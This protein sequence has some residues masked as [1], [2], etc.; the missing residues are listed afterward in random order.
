M[1]QPKLY[2]ETYG[3]QMNVNDSEVV[4]SILGKNGFEMTET[5]EDASLIILNTC[6]VRD[7][8]ENKIF[9]RL[10]VIK[11]LKKTNNELLVGVIGC[12]AERLKEQLFERD[13]K[14]DVVC[15]PDS[16]RNIPELVNIARKNN[17]AINVHLSDSETYS[18]INPMRLGHNR[19]SA[20]IS[21]MRGCDNFCTYCIVPYTRGRERSRD[22]QSIIDEAKNLEANG[23][24]EVTLLGQNVNSYNFE[25]F[26]FPK[27]M[28][29]VALAVPSMRVRFTTSH[30]KDL[31]DDLLQVMAQYNNICNFIHLPV[32]S[33]STQVLEF[34]NRKYTREWYLNRIA[35]IK[36]YLP[37]VAISTDI[38]SGFCNETEENHQDTLSLMKLVAF[39]SAFM[40]KY[41]VRPGTLAAKR[42]EDNVPEDIKLRRLNEIITL[43][44]ELS[45]KSNENDIGKTF[46]VL[47][48]GDSKKSGE[49]FFGRTPQNKVVVFPKR[50][51][52][53]GDFVN[54]TI[55]G[56]TSA[57]LIGE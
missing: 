27:L 40:F 51:A 16:Y 23:Y 55:K 46:E 28:E 33:G 12:M 18:D 48:E 2:I 31:S 14:V 19:L 20:F 44:N 22:A 57:T 1:A 35:S 13:V 45:R 43:Q 36:K 8:A 49:E 30:P 47:V 10:N 53:V 3:C 50:N 17:Q 38:L 42:Y 41:S 54:V 25:S 5:I 56:F 26:T 34:M 7:H 52:K 4:A 9:Q 32:Q 29:A 15:G 21:I 37:D 11:K 6:A 39:D 24:K